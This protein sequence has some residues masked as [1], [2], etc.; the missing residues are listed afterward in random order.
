MKIDGKGA[1]VLPSLVIGTWYSDSFI[2]Y[3]AM[4]I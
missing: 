1:G 2:K 4:K 3:Y